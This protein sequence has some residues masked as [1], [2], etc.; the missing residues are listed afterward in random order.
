MLIFLKNVY[1]KQK[2]VRKELKKKKKLSHIGLLCIQGW[3]PIAGFW[4]ALG[5]WLVAEAECQHSVN[6][7][8]CFL[9]WAFLTGS[10][11]QLGQ[12]V[13]VSWPGQ[14]LRQNMKTQLLAQW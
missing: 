5:S 13:R 2:E 7:L 9:P 12:R 3:K 4:N 14:A 10:V 8:R 1:T 6:L 11:P